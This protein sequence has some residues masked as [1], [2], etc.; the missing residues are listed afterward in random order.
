M[1]FLSMKIDD[2]NS[3]IPLMSESHEDMAALVE[4]AETMFEFLTRHKS[5][6]RW[7]VAD[8]F[9][10]YKMSDA[11]MNVIEKKIIEFEWSYV[12]KYCRTIKCY[13]TR[14]V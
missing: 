1:Y 9:N 8:D 6:D 2:N 7:V 12:D 14:N 3:G 4:Q 13:I 10:S 11:A 5:W